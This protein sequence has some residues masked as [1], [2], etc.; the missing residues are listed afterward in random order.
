[1]E[2]NTS[3][4]MGYYQRFHDKNYNDINK[5]KKILGCINIFHHKYLSYIKKEK[6]KIIG[7]RTLPQSY[8]F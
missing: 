4:I 5:K 6:L 8:R 3:I 1:M 2:N 7:C